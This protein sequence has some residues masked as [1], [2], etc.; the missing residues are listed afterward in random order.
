[1]LSNKSNKIAKN[2]IK[3]DSESNKSIEAKME[4]FQPINYILQH[5]QLGSFHMKSNLK[6]LNQNSHNAS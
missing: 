2:K 5:K 3:K 6:N 1:M 4:I